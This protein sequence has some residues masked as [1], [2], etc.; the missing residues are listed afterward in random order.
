MPA[1]RFAV[2]VLLSLTG[3]ACSGRPERPAPIPPLYSPVGE[4]LPVP[5]GTTCAEA[6]ERWFDR[7]DTKGD[8]RFD[9][10]E[11]QAEAARLFAAFDADRDGYV[12]PQEL[13]AARR[14][15]SPAA[16]PPDPAAARRRGRSIDTSPDPVMAADINL[17][18]RVSRAEFEAHV[19]RRLQ[20]ADTR[21]HGYL[22]KSDL[23]ALCS[24]QR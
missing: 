9:A 6:L 1:R 12:T 3:A 5:R 8:G 19:E 7:V 23:P 18:F 13:L 10:A 16:P 11:L 4:Y 21:R 22:G 17:D 14:A 24:G 2:L 20:A 15:A